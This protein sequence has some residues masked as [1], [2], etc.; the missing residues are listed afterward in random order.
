MFV[1]QAHSQLALKIGEHIYERDGFISF[2]MSSHDVSS[3]A[4]RF[5]L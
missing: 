5:H 4:R 2:I 1:F 3:G